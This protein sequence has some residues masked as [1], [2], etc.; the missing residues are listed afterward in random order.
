MD[1]YSPLISTLISSLS[2]DKS[3]IAFFVDTDQ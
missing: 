1:D 3:V 2:D